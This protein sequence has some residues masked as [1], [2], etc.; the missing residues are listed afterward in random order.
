M[1]AAGRSAR[2][3]APRIERC[4]RDRPAP[5]GRWGR[6]PVPPR[7]D[8]PALIPCG[9]DRPRPDDR[10]ASVPLLLPLVRGVPA[11]SGGRRPRPPPGHYLLDAGD[12]ADRRSHLPDGDLL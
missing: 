1:R 5:R 12:L 6:P 11:W 7:S 10:V 8:D 2:P 3:S 9:D 4:P